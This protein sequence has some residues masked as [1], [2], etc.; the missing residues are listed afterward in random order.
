[1]DAETQDR[2]F[3][4]FFTT[5]FSGRGLGMSAILGIMRGHN[6][7]IMVESEPG[8]GT[9]VR[10]LFPALDH[11][12]EA[13]SGEAIAAPGSTWRGEGT[14]LFVDDEEAVRNLGTFILKRLGF[15]VETAADGREALDVFTKHADEIVCVVLDLSMPHM[16]GEQAF[17]ELRQRKDDVRVILT[18]GYS[19]YDL[20]QRF[21]GKGVAAFLE[22]PYEP[23][24]LEDKLRRVLS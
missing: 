8:K 3:D 24:Q 2:L 9:T 11:R 18:S 4:P 16:D 13:A 22:K 15:E 17:R 21:S 6:G 7:A 20:E 23:Q 1:M 5:K 10:V 12:A 19:E 14:V